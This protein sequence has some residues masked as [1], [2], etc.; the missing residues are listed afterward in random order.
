MNHERYIWV[1]KQTRH[2]INKEN[3]N[4]IY[5]LEFLEIKQTV[6]SLP[7]YIWSVMQLK[8]WLA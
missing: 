6:R 3:K 8:S 2:I 1:K 4:I 7:E 5:L